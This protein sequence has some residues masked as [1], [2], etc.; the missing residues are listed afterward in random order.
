MGKMAK[1]RGWEM[2]MGQEHYRYGGEA[3]GY[4]KIDGGYK[5]KAVILYREELEVLIQET[6]RSENVV[7]ITIISS[8][9]R[10]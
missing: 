9:G 1:E 4:K 2:V 5:S 7:V 6:W 8:T 10:N 3:E